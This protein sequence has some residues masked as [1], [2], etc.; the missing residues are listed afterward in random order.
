[1][2][3]ASKQKSQALTEAAFHILLDR[4]DAEQTRAG[5]KYERLHRKLV[6]FFTYE[7][8]ECPEDCADEAINRVA[9][10]LENGEDIHD[11]DRYA[12]GVARLLF[13]EVLQRQRVARAALLEVLRQAEAP[14]GRQRA[15]AR[16]AAL[17]RCLE[18]LP[19]GSRELIISY[20]HGERTGKIENRKRLAEQ[21]KVE[22]NA[23]RN[24]VFRLREKLER[25]LEG[26]DAGETRS[27]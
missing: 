1:M 25:C 19:P 11:L 7:G 6:K 18:R 26:S 23:L 2:D 14:A 16:I 15:E 10:R 13:K 4:L 3:A 8:A 20:Y 27:R 17:E 5:E 9:R 12:L 22:V 24:R 21:Q